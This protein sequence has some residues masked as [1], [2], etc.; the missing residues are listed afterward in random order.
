MTADNINPQRSDCG[1]FA[2]VSV[3]IP[4]V[5]SNTGIDT[6]IHVSSVSKSIGVN[7]IIAVDGI[8]TNDFSRLGSYIQIGNC[9]IT[10]GSGANKRGSELS[11]VATGIPVISIGIPT[12]LG[13]R[14]ISRDSKESFHVSVT[15]K[16]CDAVCAIGASIL[17]KAI[18]QA[19][20]NLSLIE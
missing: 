15:P 17:S 20:E 12:V 14:M 4:G 1:A 2:D 18:N 19:L 7:V 10:P 3:L 8:A 9:G 13:T 5:I 11:Y 16:E 6:A